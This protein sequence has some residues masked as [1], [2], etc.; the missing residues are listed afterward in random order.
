MTIPFFLILNL[1]TLSPSPF[2]LVFYA[3][4]NYG[5][6]EEK[7]ENSIWELADEE[8]VNITVVVHE[9]INS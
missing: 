8:N 2:F 6:A 3:L 7:G 9:L 5:N 4:L 1:I